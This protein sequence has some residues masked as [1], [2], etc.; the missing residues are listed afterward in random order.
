MSSPGPIFFKQKRISSNNKEFEMFKFR[1]MK[2]QETQ[3]SDTIWTTQNDPR[4]TRIGSFLRKSNLDELP[5]FW[6]VLV[7]HMSVVGPRPERK[8]FVEKF[9]EDIPRYKVRHQVKSGISGWAQVNG[10]RG[11]TSIADRIAHDLYYIENWSIW[12]D[13]LIIWK[14]L[15][16]KKT[17]T[18]AY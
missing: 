1:T 8:F 12:V 4:V 5:Q 7:G 11:D 13:L 17:N 18:N 14:T 10:L 9:K 2:V 6:N 16:G 15:F 3:D